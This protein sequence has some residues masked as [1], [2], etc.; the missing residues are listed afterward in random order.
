MAGL[1]DWLILISHKIDKR[2]L[3]IFADVAI[4]LKTLALK[5]S[6]KKQRTLSSGYILA[7]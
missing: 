4:K 1:L 3:H 5:G 7:Y 2:D 6:G